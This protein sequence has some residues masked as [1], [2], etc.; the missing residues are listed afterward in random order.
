MP[1]G[2]L[3]RAPVSATLRPDRFRM[4]PHPTRAHRSFSL[5]QLIYFAW[6][7]ANISQNTGMTARF[8]GR[9]DLPAMLLEQVAESDL[10][11]QWDDSGEVGFDAIG[12]L[13]GAQAEP[14]R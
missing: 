4:L 13:V 5:S 12:L 8:P 1:S 14:L 3:A 11:R 6:K 9:A 2:K 10:L 7:R